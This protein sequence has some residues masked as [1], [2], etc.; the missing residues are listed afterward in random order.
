MKEDLFQLGIKAIIRNQKK[1]ILLL[2]VNTEKL[3]KPNLTA[4]WDI[5]GGRII[6][7]STIEDTL[8]REIFEETGIENIK[9][10]KKLDMVISNIRIPNGVVTY[11]L[12]LGVYLCETGFPLDIT[13]SDE[14]T[15]FKWISP[16]EAAELLSVKYPAEFCEKIKEL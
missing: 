12:I 15:Q 14:H 16:N 11:G 5:P 4:Y 7:G 2:K 13:L 10:F 6:K 8:R 1:Q 9:E 3:S